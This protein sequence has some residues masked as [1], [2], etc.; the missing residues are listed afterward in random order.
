MTVRKLLL[1]G[2]LTLAQLGALQAA[3]VASGGKLART[4]CVTCHIVAPGVGPSQVTAGIP[5]FMAIAAKPG[6][7]AIK[8]KGA[9]LAPHP[10]MQQVQLTTYELDNLAAYILSL[11]EPR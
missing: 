10:P 8:I 1:A 6:E 9:I 7:T 3:D 4:V 11:N 5:S 2:A